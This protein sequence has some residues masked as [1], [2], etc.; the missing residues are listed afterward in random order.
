MLVQLLPLKKHYEGLI[1]NCIVLDLI[2]S[3]SISEYSFM[4]NNI[5]HTEWCESLIYLISGWHVIKPAFYRPN[6]P[7]LFDWF[8][9]HWLSHSSIPFSGGIAINMDFWSQ[10]LT[11]PQGFLQKCL[12]G[13]YFKPVH[14]SYKSIIV[15]YYLSIVIIRWVTHQRWKVTSLKH[16]FCFGWRKRFIL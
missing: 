10:D 13:W 3:A 5:T 12:L 4:L 1:C 8:L 14:Y 9:F 2:F 6:W 16:L 7:C 11:L 15:Y